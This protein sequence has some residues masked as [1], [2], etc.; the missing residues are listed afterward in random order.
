MLEVVGKGTVKGKNDD[1]ISLLDTEKAIDVVIMVD[2]D[3]MSKEAEERIEELVGNSA[4]QTCAT[5]IVRFWE[6]NRH[7]IINGELNEDIQTLAN[8]RRS[9]RADINSC[10]LRLVLATVENNPDEDNHLH[11]VLHS[12]GRDRPCTSAIYTTLRYMEFNGVVSEMG[13]RHSSSPRTPLCTITLN[14]HLQQRE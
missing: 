14:T 4:K 9:V 6:E 13:V 8:Q 3:E 12:D 7:S 5:L 11:S 2:D 1:N 10:R